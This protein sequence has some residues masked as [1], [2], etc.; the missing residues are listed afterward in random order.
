MSSWG[1]DADASEDN[2]S[3]SA[4]AFEDGVR[5]GAFALHWQAHGHRYGIPVETDVAV[6]AGKTVV[7]NVSRQVIPLARRRYAATVVVLVDAPVDVR[8]AR[9]TARDREGP[10]EV[11]GRLER[12]VAGFDLS[13]ADLVVDNSGAREP[14]AD[15]IVRRLQDIRS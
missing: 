12:A 13:D 11:R 15:L 1:A 14:A 3:V 4:M 5:R 8:A 7:L 9:L 6:R 2:A 10:E